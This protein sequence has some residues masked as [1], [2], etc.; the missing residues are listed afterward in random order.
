M[1]KAD[2]AIGIDPTLSYPAR[3]PFHP[4]ARYPELAPDTPL[5]PENKVYAHVR[6][7]LRHLG[8][9]AAADDTPRWNPLG[10][11]I[12]PG[13]KVLIKPNLVL[14][15]RGASH[16][17]DAVVTHGSVLRPLIDYALR[18][19][20]G[21]G[22]VIV[23]DAPHGNA[24]F[25][26]IV[27]ANGLR[28]TVEWFRQRGEPVRLLDFR[29]Y[30]YAPGPSGFIDG[31][32]RE[33][34]GD[35]AGYRIVDV[36]ERSFLK[37]LPHLERLYGSDFDREFIVAQH[38]DGHHRYCV[39]GTL[40]A[41]DVV[42]SVPK[43]KTH[44]KVGVTLNAKNLVGVNGDKNYLAHYRVGS[45][46]QG[47]DEYPPTSSWLLRL[48]RWWLRFAADKFLAPNT[49]AGRTL[50]KVLHWPMRFVFLFYLALHDREEPIDKGDW[51]GND[52]AWRMCLDLN[53]ILR[54]A[55]RDGKLH[56]TPQ[57][58]LFAVLDGIVAGEGN[59]PMEPEARRAGYLAIGGDPFLVDHLCA[60]H[61]GF[62][63][64]KLPVLDAAR[65][66]PRLAYDPDGAVV[67]CRRQGEPVDWR[68][69][70]LRFKPHHA[71]RGKIER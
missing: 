40:L 31:L 4:P 11:V 60:W 43:M 37:E 64:D 35:P 21:K 12:R 59:G 30:I 38:R 68:E 58:R 22:E 41:A 15:Y 26:R 10:E 19:L 49:Q 9:D 3:A 5:D 16:D 69:V 63:P 50:Y 2:V 27:A 66:S 42:I 13:D 71:W 65:R 61:M 47:G 67:D 17:I 36:G 25:D 46:E 24:D 70:D 8:L 7:C 23:G 14:H 32:C 33:V 51:C 53:E 56:D 6:D 45:A 52:T 18:A 57:R 62:A 55:D 54:F 20:D 34:E 39:T 48:W 28:A 44:K 1:T 29:K